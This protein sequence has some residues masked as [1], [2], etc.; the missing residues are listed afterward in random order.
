MILKVKL[1]FL[2]GIIVPAFFL[3]SC[4][5]DKNTSSDDG[6]CDSIIHSKAAIFV[7]KLPG[8]LKESSGLIFLNN[9]IWTIN[10]SGGKNILYGYNPVPGKIDR[11]L[12]VVNAVNRDWETLA[13]DDEYV[14]IGDV[15]NNRGNRTDLVVY[16]IPISAVAQGLKEVEAEKIR[17][18]W[19]DQEKFVWLP[20]KHPFDCEAM[21]SFGDSLYLFSKDWMSG[22]TRVYGLPKVPG[23]YNIGPLGS[24]NVNALV[25][26]AAISDDG[27][28]LVLSS[29][30]KY[31]PSVWIFRDFPG[32]SFFKGKSVQIKFPDLYDAQT[33][34]ITFYGNDTILVSSEKSGR[35][36]QRIYSF[37]LS[38]LL[39]A[40]SVNKC[41]SQ[42]P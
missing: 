4:T 42:I 25:T 28:C 31:I 2:A 27:R 16:K 40:A 21:V 12:K 18:T 38:E 37:R 9:R 11:N 22:K 10:D 8:V 29:Y 36:P 35:F 30:F 5:Q 19:A 41:S 34:G 33:E 7:N 3:V 17:F 1:R 24:Y 13:H 32:N 15:G 39:E 14:Y 20:Q 26:G 23:N 6:R